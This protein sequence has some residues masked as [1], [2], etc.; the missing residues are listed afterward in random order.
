VRPPPRRAIWEITRRCN[1]RCAHCLVDAGP[2]TPDELTTEEG[3][4]LV[5][6]FAALGVRQLT[7]TGGEPLLRRD[8][9]ELAARADA[10][11]LRVVLSTN[12]HALKGANLQ[13]ALAS[14]VAEV[15]LSL[16]GLCDTHDQLRRY[17]EESARR[18]SFHEVV[19][20]IERLGP[21][22][23]R[24]TVI[25]SVDRTNVDELSAI[26]GLL[27][28]L[29]VRSWMV[30]LSHPT[31]R[32]RATDRMLPRERLPALVRFLVSIA[33]DPV[34]PPFVHTT[35]GYLS[36]DEPRL[37]ASGRIGGVAVW[38]G[39]PCGV[40]SVGIEPDGGI[41]GCPNQVGAPFVVGNVR[42]EP[43]ADIW[44]DR[45][46]WHWL[47]PAPAE[48]GGTCAPCP[49]KAVCGGGCPCVSWA[50]TGALHRDPWCVR[51]VE[52]AT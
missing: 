28:T 39:S 44:H 1:L 22:P 29:P 37:R 26:H 13:R 41:K 24:T 51:A 43:L 16:D 17:P 34:L 18:S 33:D 50:T 30:Q 46:R 14:H 25:T 38:R 10:H 11:G 19:A 7:L 12:G 4:A 48:V 5:D 2:G 6:A 52:A 42:A 9:P 40:E 27:R 31:G 36:R 3:L 49:M 15:A 20:A 8:W 32:Q 45:D 47:S 21:T 35:I 23:I